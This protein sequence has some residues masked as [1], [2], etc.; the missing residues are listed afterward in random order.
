MKFT[1]NQIA[2][3]VAALSLLLSSIALYASLQQ[4]RN[5]YSEAVLIQ[6]GA[7]PIQEIKLGKSPIEFTVQ[8]T[9][10][11]NI[12]YYMKV[13][14]NFLFIDGTNRKPTDFSYESQIISLSKAELPGDSFTHKI[15]LNAGETAPKMHPLAFLSD[16]DFYLSVEILNARNGKNLFSSNCYY[17]FHRA[18]QSY[19]LEQPVFDSSGDAERRQAGCHP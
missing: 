6:P 9:S 11:T 1:S 14:S 18:S 17:K 4:Y 19:G 7:L 2:N 16:A 8:N 5:D 10:R 12:R 3:S 13:S 15:N